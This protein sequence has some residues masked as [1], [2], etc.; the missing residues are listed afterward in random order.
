MA[1]VTLER[2]LSR[3]LGARTNP[4]LGVCVLIV[5]SPLGPS[6]FLFYSLL[7]YLYIFWT[8]YGV[9]LRAHRTS[10][11]FRLQTHDMTIDVETRI[12]ME[13]DDDDDDDDIL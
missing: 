10:A 4:P 1:W 9:G 12:V 13:N 7:F 3:E 8:V 11:Y 2:E 6:S 5:S